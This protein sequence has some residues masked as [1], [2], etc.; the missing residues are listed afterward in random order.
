MMDDAIT[1]TR[2][3]LE[4]ILPDHHP[5]WHQLTAAKQRELLD[6]AVEEVARSCIEEVLD[7]L[8]EKGTLEYVGRDENG[9]NYKLRRQ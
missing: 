6:E 8:A 7:S 2:R 3:W 5:N 9:K 4:T 1:I